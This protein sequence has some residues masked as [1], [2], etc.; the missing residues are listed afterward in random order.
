MFEFVNK[1]RKIFTK[2][3]L[4]KL[5][6]FFI[7]GALAVS[8]FVNSSKQKVAGNKT[9]F[10]DL[11]KEIVNKC[12][13][14]VYRPTCYEDE[15]P[16]LMD[17]FTME[18]AFDVTRLV[19]DLDRT[20]T[21]CHVLGHKLSAI[22]TAKDPSKW[23]DVV[24]RSPSGLCSNG[25][26]HG[27][28]QER[29]RTEALTDDEIDMYKPE[30]TDV[31]EP[32][33]TWQPTGLEQGTCYH[34]LG[35]LFMYITSAQIERSV[36]LCDELAI[37]DNGQRNYSKLCYDGTFMQI[38][39]PLEAEDFALV[40]GKVPDKTDVQKFCQQYKAEARSSCW[41]ESWPLVRSEVMQSDGL[42]Q[43][44]EK[45]VLTSAA[46]I[47]RCYL[48]M[49]YVLTAQFQFDSGKITTLCNGLPYTRQGQCFA[50]AASRLIETDYRNIEKSVSLCASA[51]S[52]LQN[53]CFSELL[54]YSTYNFHAETP[55]FYHLCNSLPEQWKMKC[56]NSTSK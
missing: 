40:E 9:A 35:H 29:F 24:A 43:F 22:E 5:L 39:Q 37:K 20:Y 17:T 12:V 6:I 16:K 18:Q 38:F 11:A 26:I 14:A 55:E 44:C 45:G 36:T 42:V 21:Y 41:T 51:K 53:Q 47:D 52:E 28:F 15:I 30:F 10:P 32:R 8:G 25:S 56:L 19:Q 54:F 3:N 7:F 27:A 49:F 4:L 50:N 2:D 33:G 34:A 48:G 46:D 13:Q 23:K 1:M 31:C